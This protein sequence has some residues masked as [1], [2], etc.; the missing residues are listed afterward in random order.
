MDSTS[1]VESI[2]LF[3]K[4]VNH[5]PNTKKHHRPHKKFERMNPQLRYGK[6]LK[7]FEKKEKDMEC[8]ES[9]K[10]F[11][12]PYPKPSADSLPLELSPC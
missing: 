11:L 9:L 10:F 3:Q 5:D 1:E 4:K 12:T 7:R 2:C 6:A 8:K